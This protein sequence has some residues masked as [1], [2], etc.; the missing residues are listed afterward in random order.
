MQRRRAPPSPGDTHP[1]R[2]RIRQ[3]AVRDLGVA[4]PTQRHWPTPNGERRR[5]QP[6]QHLWQHVASRQDRR[7]EA[8]V[9]K[10]CPREHMSA[11]VR[12]HTF[13]VCCRVVKALEH[14]RARA[15]NAAAANSVR[16]YSS[17]ADLD[18][19]L[20][21]RQSRHLHH[22]ADTLWGIGTVGGLANRPRHCKR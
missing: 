18:Q 17:E 10:S 6:D 2:F 5:V 14:N 13:N 12:V 9:V 7:E 22:R 1:V 15:R 16:Q 4:S 8:L 19:L 21:K 20:R 3:P 11:R